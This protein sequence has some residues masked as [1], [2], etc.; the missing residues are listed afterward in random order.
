M[1][2]QAHN[3]LCRLK[4]RLLYVKQTIDGLKSHRSEHFQDRLC[5]PRSAMA[6]EARDFK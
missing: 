4:A 6:A 1:A 3:R 5:V 2:L